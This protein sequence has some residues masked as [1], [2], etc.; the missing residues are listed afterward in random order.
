MAP[1]GLLCLGL[2][3]LMSASRAT[4]V[5]EVVKAFCLSAYQ[6]DLKK[7]GRTLS[8]SQIDRTCG[9]VGERVAQGS[10][11]EDAH[12]TCGHPQEQRSVRTATP[13]SGAGA[14][15]IN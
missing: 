6:A 9:C 1:I 11:V 15:S 2:M 14:G 4:S 7:Q 8:L 5:S 12:D 10:D 13:P 3:A